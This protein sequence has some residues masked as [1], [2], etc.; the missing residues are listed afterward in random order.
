MA[1]RACQGKHLKLQ[2]CQRSLSEKYCPMNPFLDKAFEQY[3]RTSPL[4]L[5]DIGASGGVHERWK[6]LKEYLRVV[7]FEP[8][9]RAFRD[10]MGAEGT[11]WSLHIYQLC[12]S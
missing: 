7:G 4:T 8:D 11:R 1:G 5:I 3:Y 12:T 6:S 2:L 10:L 9:E